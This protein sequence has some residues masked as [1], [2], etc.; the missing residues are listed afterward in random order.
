MTTYR[1]YNSALEAMA[2]EAQ[3]SANLRQI[4]IGAGYTVVEDRIIG[5]VEGEDAIDATGTERWA[6]IEEI[7][8][9]SWGFLDPVEY[10][11]NLATELM[12]GVDVG[13]VIQ[14]EPEPEII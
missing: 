8:S 2:A 12:V 10:R 1:V 5:K 13:T 7:V 3:I 14:V 6:D 9:G 11:P 4:A